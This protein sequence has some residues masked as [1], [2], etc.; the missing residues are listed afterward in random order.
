MIHTAVASSQAEF[1][2]DDCLR[3]VAAFPKGRLSGGKRAPKAQ[4]ATSWE[5]VPRDDIPRQTDT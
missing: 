1:V 5:L 4:N 3:K 2:Q